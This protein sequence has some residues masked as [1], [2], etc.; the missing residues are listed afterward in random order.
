MIEL[1]LHLK[2]YLDSFPRK[3]KYAELGKSARLTFL[4]SVPKVVEVIRNTYIILFCIYS[5][6]KPY[7]DL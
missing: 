3:L 7:R 4:V 1:Y 2:I 6:T 5:S